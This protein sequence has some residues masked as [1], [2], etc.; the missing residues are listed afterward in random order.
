M[1]RFCKRDIPYAACQ[2]NCHIVS[3]MA[4]R[5]TY[6]ISQAL[7]YTIPFIQAFKQA[8]HSD[9]WH[10]HPI[11]ISIIHCNHYT[12]THEIILALLHHGGWVSTG[13][14][15]YLNEQ[16]CPFSLY[17]FAFRLL[18]SLRILLWP[19]TTSK[20]GTY[21]VIYIGSIFH[22]CITSIIHGYYTRFMLFPPSVDFSV[23]STS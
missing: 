11:Q 21:R 16:G 7:Q 22:L 6:S 15:S 9:D 13:F 17:E 10:N 4:P 8:T 12:Y 2:H 5:P 23:L 20:E 3:G 19:S 14:S 18:L 1:I